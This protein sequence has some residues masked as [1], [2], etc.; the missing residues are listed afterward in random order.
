MIEDMFFLLYL[1]DFFYSIS[2]F[3]EN[4]F[5]DVGHPGCG[6]CPYFFLLLS[7]HIKEASP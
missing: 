1:F 7:H 2:L 3:L 6:A 4:F 5:E